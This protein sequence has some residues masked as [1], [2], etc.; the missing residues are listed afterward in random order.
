[1]LNVIVKA[2]NG[3]AAGYVVYLIGSVIYELGKESVNKEATNPSQ[4]SFGRV[5]NDG[6]S[7]YI[8]IDGQVYRR[9]DF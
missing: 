1:M 5:D 6:H 7:E 4:T 9:V 8:V 3:I 2:V